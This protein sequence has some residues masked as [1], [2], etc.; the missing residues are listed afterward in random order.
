ML[1]AAALIFLA[2]YGRGSRK[3]ERM[4]ASDCLEAER[5]RAEDV[6][7]LA[8]ARAET[9]TL[10]R[11]RERLHAEL[12]RSVA[13]HQ[14]ALHLAA[15]K[16]TAL[17]AA[18]AESRTRAEHL[19][20]KETR[21]L[22]GERSLAE[23]QG[24]LKGTTAALEAARKQIE[25]EAG[26]T[27]RKLK[28]MTDAEEKLGN[29]FKVLAAEIF[30]EKSQRF[31]EENE[32][33]LGGL[34]NP[35]RE[36]MGEF[37]QKVEA[38]QQ[39]GVVGRTELR[40]QLGHLKS[41]NEQLSSEA[42]NLARA[43]KGSSKTQGDWGEVLLA[44]M[45]ESAGL[46]PDKEYRVQQTLSTDEGR[47]MRP[48]IILDL[49][50][51]KHL[52]IDSKVSLNSYTE[53]CGCIDEPARKGL[54]ERHTSAIREHVDGLSQKRYQALRQLRSVDFVVMFIPIE[55]AY[56]L[57]LAHDEALWQRAWEREVL[58]VSPRTLCPVIRT[59]AHIWKQERQT[60]NV[61]EIVRQAGALYDKIAIFAD[62]FLD[63]G[64]RIDAAKGS[65]EKAYGQLRTGNGDVL[66][67][68]DRLRQL[69]VPTAREMPLGLAID[70]GMEAM[71]ESA[72]GNGEG[73]TPS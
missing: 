40:E 33:S 44:R 35:L 36:R 16:D 20:E 57:A 68:V 41:L 61:E 28:L 13:A 17:A 42:S 14:T 15:A 46:R 52:V 34:L 9:D 38:L 62:T 10:A 60:R 7:A 22:A 8:L 58:L 2:G 51:G 56:L 63:V 50:G 21:L 26:E 6:Q 70:P 24:E 27:D 37:Q 29:Q 18:E 25:L 72:Y 39:E 47:Q 32:R 11:D 43:L 66:T 64:K 65:Y 31:R 73:H 3:S 45:L 48:D 54:A 71:L 55:P 53:Y 23:L 5:R 19:R 59:V 49:P 69:G 12:A 1:L 30:R 67:R 4:R